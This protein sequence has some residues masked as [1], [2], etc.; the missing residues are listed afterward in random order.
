MGTH[1]RQSAEEMREASLA[2]RYMARGEAETQ[3]LMGLDLLSLDVVGVPMVL[4]LER[5]GD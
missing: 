5:E 3:A 4:V 1:P 2:G